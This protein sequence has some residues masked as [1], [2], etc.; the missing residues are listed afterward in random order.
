[1][2]QASLQTAY[3]YTHLAIFAGFRVDALMRIP[4]RFNLSWLV[5]VNGVF[6]VLDGNMKNCRDIC[7][8]KDAGNII[9]PGLPGCVKTGCTASPAFKSRFCTQHSPRSCSTSYDEGK[10]TDT[11]HMYRVQE[12]TCGYNG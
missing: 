1:M 2:S 12:N 11:L 9:Y 3:V 7:Y 6:I 10:Y 4:S 8:A 5:R